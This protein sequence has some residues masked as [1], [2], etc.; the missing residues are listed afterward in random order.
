[1][2]ILSLKEFKKWVD[3]TVRKYN[4]DYKV[5]C[6]EFQSQGKIILVDEDTAKTGMSKCNPEQFDYE[7]GLAIAYAKLRGLEVPEI[8]DEL[9]EQQLAFEQFLNFFAEMLKKYGREVLEEIEAEKGGELNSD[10]QRGK[11]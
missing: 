10:L 8:K 5:K 1:M 11:T 2:K 4:A 7:T 6:L 9:R 3:E